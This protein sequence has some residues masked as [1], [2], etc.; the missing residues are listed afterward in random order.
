MTG[1]RNNEIKISIPKKAQWIIDRITDAGYE[2]YIVGGCVRDSIL[3]REPED[4]DITTSARPE[5]VKALFARTIDTG[6][7]HGTV[8]VMLD[9]E[10]FE[11]TTYRIDGK[12]EDNRHP[13]EVTFTPNLREDLRRRD[14]TI[15][16]MAYNERTGLVDLYGGL[17]DIERKVI[18]CVGNAE[19]RF[20]EDA[21]RIMRAIRFSAQLGYTIE[22]ET[23]HAIRKLA[24]N[25]AAISAERIQVE[26]VKLLVSPHPDYLRDAY[27]LGVTK[28]FLP[29][30]D[31]C[32]ETP[33][34][35]PHHMYNVGEHTLHSVLA[36]QPERVYR[37]AMLLHDIG[38]PA[39]LQIDENGITHFHGHNEVG[40]GMAEAILRRLRFD[41]DTIYK[42][43]KIVLY[44]DY[45]NSVEPGF[46]VVRRAVSR[47]GEDIFPM[48]F[49]VK[50]ADVAAQSDFMREEKLAMIDGWEKVYRQIMEEKQ[51]FSLKDLAVS[52]KDL[53]AAGYKPGPEI[54]RKLQEL[55]ELV[56]DDPEWNTREKLLEKASE[57]I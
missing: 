36:I 7:Q 49:P 31:V 52:G 3:G 35:H 5:E 27:E 43:C 9:Q 29:E 20:T 19:E 21:L 33:Q 11:V 18:R 13:T 22:E 40:E 26:L 23:K 10:G 16:A 55:L 54:G 34:N 2:A 25:L 17:D 8:T 48:L 1:S 38:K 53:I 32:M 28:V 37:I 56:L 15:N 45:G 4:W 50:R 57:R 51:C 24:P 6:I 41:N 42:V 30:F 12:Y 39:T 14:F 44:H 47:I 46:R